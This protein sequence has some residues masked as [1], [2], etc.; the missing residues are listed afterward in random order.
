MLTYGRNIMSNTDAAKVI[1]AVIF[2]F[3]GT[4]ADT[5]QAIIAAKQDTMRNLGLEVADEKT[6]AST[7]GLTA[8]EGFKKTYPDLSDDILDRCVA[9]YR[10]L[11][12]DN[13][14]KTPPKLFDGVE[15]VLE[16]L[17][18]RGIVCTIASSR[19]KQSLNGFLK[20][21]GIE[22]YF[23]YILGGDDTTRQKPDPEPVL[24]TLKELSLKAEEV[25]VVGDMPMDI[26][27]GRD[28]GAYTCAVTYGN[29][30]KEALAEA[31]AHIIVDNIYELLNIDW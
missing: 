8:K 23:T 4:L 10:S 20:D 27:M 18:E 22:R 28:A 17:W 5:A 13:V 25:L 3:D 24:K 6:C 9:M 31:G 2:D 30:T 15:N 11:F 26:A 14:K 29:S 21:M 19:H 16:K 1:K 7:I 12:E